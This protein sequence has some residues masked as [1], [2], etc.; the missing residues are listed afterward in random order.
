HRQLRFFGGSLLITGL[1][2][3]FLAPR[4]AGARF[5]AAPDG[6]AFFGFPVGDEGFL[7]GISGGEGGSVRSQSIPLPARGAPTLHGPWHSATTA[8]RA[9]RPR[10]PRRGPAPRPCGLRAGGT[11]GTA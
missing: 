1:P 8:P 3:A 11:P 6:D 2:A 10:P 4:F 7:V 5:F 9:R